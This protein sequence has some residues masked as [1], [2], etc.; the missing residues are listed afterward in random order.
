M[1]D[2]RIPSVDERCK[3]V[4]SA[5]ASLSPFSLGLTARSIVDGFDVAVSLTPW[6]DCDPEEQ[7]VPTPGAWLL[8]LWAGGDL[9]RA[10]IEGHQF[11]TEFLEGG[12]VAVTD[13][14]GQFVCRDVPVGARLLYGSQ[15]R[16]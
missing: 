13:H 12:F 6:S 2:R 8:T 14:R 7:Q 3:L 4:S 9:R 5:L 1:F 16:I 15:I 11:C 10:V